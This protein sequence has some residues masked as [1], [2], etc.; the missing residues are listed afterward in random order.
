MK[1]RKC[2]YNKTVVNERH[3]R[4]RSF[5]KEDCKIEFCKIDGNWS[6]WS[7]WTCSSER[8]LS[9]Q[10]RSRRCDNPKPF[11]GGS[12]NGTHEERGICNLDNDTDTKIPS[13]YS[14]MKYLSNAYLRRTHKSLVFNEKPDEIV[15]NCDNELG[16]ILKRFYKNYTIV[17]SFNGDDLVQKAK[18]KRKKYKL[19]FLSSSLKN[20]L[21]LKP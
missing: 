14:Q 16:S 21:N 11:H 5:A 4:G 18:E 6:Q 19:S 9:I 10:K 20:R 13:Y 15:L 17:W 7:E 12:C 8:T 2:E 3:C 1:V